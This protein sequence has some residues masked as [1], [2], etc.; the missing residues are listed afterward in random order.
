MSRL[1]ESEYVSLLNMALSSRDEPPV[2][3]LADCSPAL[4][5]RFF[6]SLLE[7][8]RTGT[9]P[10]AVSTFQHRCSLLSVLGALEDTARARRARYAS[11]D[12]KCARLCLP[13]RLRHGFQG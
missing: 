1:L 2:S 5:I 11:G 12:L 10:V 7:V 6:R 9:P 4:F 3:S 13:A 8:K